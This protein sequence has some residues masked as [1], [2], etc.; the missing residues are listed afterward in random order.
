M[1]VTDSELA[2]QICAVW[3]EV[4]GADSVGLSDNFFD[5]GG[6]S[7]DMIKIHTRLR[8]LLSKDV[9]LLDMFFVYPTIAALVDY[10]Q[11][12]PRAAA[13]S[14]SAGDGARRERSGRAPRRRSGAE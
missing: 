1:T 7:V 4:L 11:P 8:P 9:P 5:L 13:P 3:R 12:K 14:A 2:G 10:L 6:T